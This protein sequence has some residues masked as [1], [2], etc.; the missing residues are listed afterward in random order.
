MKIFES[1]NSGTV[2][3]ITLSAIVA[4]F[5]LLITLTMGLNNYGIIPTVILSLIIILTIL[6]F[7]FNSLDKIVLSNDTLVLKKRL[8]N[9]EIKLSDIMKIERLA[10]SNLTMTAGSKGFFGF[11]GGTM[12]NSYSYVKDRSKMVKI[13]TLEKNIIFSCE[14]PDE[15]VS[16]LN[17]LIFPSL[18]DEV[19]N[20]VV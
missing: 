18:T 19:A 13:T 15:L 2:T 20:K 16:K 1:K 8:G 7:Y 11:V 10:Y 17:D 9:E 6:Y 4:M 14:N 12:D 3:I 5:S